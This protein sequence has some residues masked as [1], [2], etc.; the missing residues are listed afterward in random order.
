MSLTDR[1]L[2]ASEPCAAP[3]W[4]SLEL[5][6][7]SKEEA[8][9]IAD[10][11][12]F[13]DPT[14]V[15]E[16]PDGYW[17][18]QQQENLAAELFRFGC[19]QPV[20]T[21]AALVFVDEVLMRIY[22]FPNYPLSFAEVAEHLGAPDYVRMRPYHGRASPFC[23]VALIWL[24]RGVIVGF[25][26]ADPFP[27]P[28]EPRVRCSDSAGGV[29]IDAGLPVQSIF[30]GLPTDNSFATVPDPGGDFPW[31]GFAEP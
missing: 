8:L 19:R 14:E 7:S 20:Q 24:S 16:S 13:I 4:Y 12:P 30:Y 23:S 17:D 11:L 15:S 18:V 1:S 22:T 21:C 25:D 2:L 10:S 9:A 28:G 5:G 26:A 27:K 3:C 6:V 31:I 29:G